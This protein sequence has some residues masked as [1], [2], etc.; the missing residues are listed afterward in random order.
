MN[1]SD[2]PDQFV[3]DLVNKNF[4][5]IIGDDRP[6]IKGGKTKNDDNITAEQWFEQMSFMHLMFFMNAFR[7]AD[8]RNL[9]NPAERVFGQEVMDM[10]LGVSDAPS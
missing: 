4:R 5:F 6:L 3:I 7:E 1:L 2:K 8:K 9:M 10:I